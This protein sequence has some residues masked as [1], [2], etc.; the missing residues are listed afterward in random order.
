MRIAVRHLHQLW[1]EDENGACFVP[2]M[3]S[4]LA[5]KPTGFIHAHSQ[6][7]CRLTEEISTEVTAE[8]V[9]E[10]EHPDIVDYDDEQLCRVC[11]GRRA[12]SS[13]PWRHGHSR[14]TCA[15]AWAW[16]PDLVLA[17]T[18][19]TDAERALQK[20]RWDRERPSIVIVTNA[21]NT[22]GN[23]YGPILFGL[24]EAIIISA[25]SCE[26]CMNALFWTYGV[27]YKDDDEGYPEMS[28]PWKKSGTS[29]QLCEHMG[30]AY[31]PP[32]P[33]ELTP[34]R[35]MRVSAEDDAPF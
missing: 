27:K 3:A 11:G 20:E 9:A 30:Y 24:E 28:E 18:R 22:E 6:P 8:A 12:D 10:C 5:V 4:D 2:D 19:P 1:F 15:S 21:G 14:F 13:A 26:R 16:N 17:M 32:G 34:T 29:C 7:V 25:R 23:K 35:A 33:D 31:E